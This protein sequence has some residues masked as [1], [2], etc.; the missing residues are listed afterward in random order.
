[1][2]TRIQ[3]RLAD[4]DAQIER[5][6]RQRAAAVANYGSMSTEARQ[7]RAA[8][9]SFTAQKLNL[10]DDAAALKTKP[11]TLPSSAAKPAEAE[12]G[13]NAMPPI[14]A[15]S[16]FRGSLLVVV[17]GAGG[18]GARVVPPMMQMLRRGDHVAI[19]DHDMV[20]D[21]NLARQHFT[22]R[23]I[24][25]PKAVVL[26]ERYRR[27]GIN[28]GAFQLKADA[29]EAPSQIAHIYR[30]LNPAA[31]PTGVVVVGCVDGSAGRRGAH[32]LM[33]QVPQVGVSNAA[34]ID[35]G[36][37]MRGGQVL[38]TSSCWPLKL[39]GEKVPGGA[40]SGSYK[41]G[42]LP[43]AMPQLLRETAAEREQENCAERIDMQSVQVNMMAASAAINTLSWLI[44]GLPFTSAG[45]FFSTFNTMQ[46]IRLMGVDRNNIVQPETTFALSE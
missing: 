41:L 14:I 18:N 11:D 45:A 29:K 23:D 37:E 16:Q 40:A 26:A 27:E 32:A 35:I 28:V 1:M 5:A 43:T 24:G 39:V 3:E 33:Q 21:R 31:R 2:S 8:L 6:E 12:A 34:W 15:T 19:V 38:L 13:T 46:P 7:A 20:E 22:S 30:G 17:V 36:N 25:A 10:T 44:L 9:A 42:G 4:L